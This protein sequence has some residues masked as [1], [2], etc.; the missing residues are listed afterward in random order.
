[1]SSLDGISITR[2]GSCLFHKFISSYIVSGLFCPLCSGFQLSGS[3]IAIVLPLTVAKCFTYYV[4]GDYEFLLI[5][6]VLC[7]WKEVCRR[8]GYMI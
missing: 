1:M 5:K 2:T 3:V 8:I 7:V 6:A 4:C